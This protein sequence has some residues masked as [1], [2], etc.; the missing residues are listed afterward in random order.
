MA[1]EKETFRLELELLLAAYP[2]KR[3]YNRSDIMA[4]TGRGRKWLD[5]HGFTGQEY[6][7]V[8]VARQLACIHEKQWRRRA[9]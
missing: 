3:I 2:Q 4:Y 5:S 1:R 7:A 9:S 8:D 6:T